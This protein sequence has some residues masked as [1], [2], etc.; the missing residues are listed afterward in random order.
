MN[1]LTINTCLFFISVLFASCEDKFSQIVEVDLPE[2]EPVLSVSAQ[3]SNKDSLL[4]VAVSRTWGIND[5]APDY[6]LENATVRLLK[7]GVQL[8][9]FL[10][11]Q[12]TFNGFYCSENQIPWQEVGGNYRLEVAAPNFPTV[13]A[14]QVILKEIPIA[15]ATYEKQGTLSP[16]GDK[17]DEITIEFNDPAGEENYYAIRVFHQYSFYYEPE[18]TTYITY[19]N[20]YLESY[21]PLAEIGENGIMLLSDAA[22]DGKKASF[23]AYYYNYNDVDKIYVHLVHL[24]K[25]KFLY[26]RSLRQYQ[27]ADGNPFAEPVTVSSNIENGT[28]IFSLETVN[29]LEIEP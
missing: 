26:L 24:P 10:P 2:H 1:K 21:D 29:I 12:A 27:D 8:G 16:D 17:V 9:A 6:F 3:F 28:G 20:M 23:R 4:K 5:Q 18:D 15:T 14:E 25:E 19:E 7:D 13:F 11:G 22:F